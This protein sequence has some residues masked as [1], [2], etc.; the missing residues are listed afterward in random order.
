MGG[1]MVERASSAGHNASLRGSD[2]DGDVRSRISSSQGN[3][4]QEKEVWPCPR[5]EA[6]CAGGARVKSER[7]WLAGVASDQ[8]HSRGTERVVAEGHPAASTPAEPPGL[9]LFP[10]RLRQSATKP[11][12]GPRAGGASSGA[13]GEAEQGGASVC[14]RGLQEGPVLRGSSCCRE[15]EAVLPYIRGGAQVPGHGGGR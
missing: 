9:L 15:Q 7:V 12:F 1:S 6:A 4:V 10:A 13:Q 3:G 5:P 14:G 2:G 8:G 11:G